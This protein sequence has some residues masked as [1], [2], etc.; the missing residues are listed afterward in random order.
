T[1]PEAAAWWYLH[2]FGAAYR[3]T[4]ASLATTIVHR[5]HDIGRGG[6]I[7]FFRQRV[8]G[9][10]VYRNEL[11]VLMRRDLSLVAITGNLRDDAVQR[12]HTFSL[13]HEQALA[14]AFG[15]L[16]SLPVD[17]GDIHATGAEK[18]GYFYYDMT[19]SGAVARAGLD[20]TEAARVKPLLFPLPGQLV[21]GY[22][23]E[24]FAGNNRNPNSDA[25]AYV[26]AADNGRL[27][28]RRNLT[29]RDSFDYQV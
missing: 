9:V 15:N 25:Y 29:D 8:N 3:L 20:L 5:V 16:Y 18:G 27:L 10:D 24:F 13:S 23:V 22:Y 14:R 19:P 28:L 6:I 1:T 12:R 11:K 2:R 21:P 17:V 7:V 26:I 4:K